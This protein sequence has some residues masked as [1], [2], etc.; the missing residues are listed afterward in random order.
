MKFAKII[1]KDTG[2]WEGINSTIFFSGCTFKCPGCFNEVAQDFNY[3]LD[4]N[5]GIEDLFIEYAKDE[6][7]T[8]VCILGGEPFQQPFMDLYRFVFRLVTEVGKP[9]HIWTGYKYEDLVLDRPIRRSLLE[10]IDTLIDGQFEQEKKDLSLLYRGSSNQRVIDV[11]KSLACGETCLV[12][13]F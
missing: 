9:I 6:H 11:E 10:L 7:V 13:G 12:E 2:N 8:G 5:K 3:G 4:F 1:K